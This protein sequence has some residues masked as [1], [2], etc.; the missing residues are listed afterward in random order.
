MKQYEIPLFCFR[1][2]ALIRFPNSKFVTK[3]GWQVSVALEY[4]INEVP[5]SENCVFC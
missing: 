4:I 1:V 5:D 2:F 3:C